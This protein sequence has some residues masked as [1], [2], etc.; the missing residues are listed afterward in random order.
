M[1]QLTFQSLCRELKS[2]PSLKKHAEELNILTGA[3]ASLIENPVAGSV[4]VFIKALSEKEKLISLGGAVL[5]A[6]LN[7]A[8]AEDYS[9]RVKR[10]QEAY[11]IIYFTAFFDELDKRLPDNIRR[12]IQLSLKEKQNLFYSSVFSEGAEHTDRREIMLPDLVCGYDEVDKFLKDMYGSMANRLQEFVRGLSFQDVAEDADIRIFDEVIKK[13]STAAVERFHDQCLILCSKFNEFYIFMQM[14]HEKRKQLKWDSQYQN[15]L[16]IAMR[17]TTSSETG[18]ANLKEIIM[19]LPKQI[20]EEKIQEIVNGLIKTYQDSINRPLIET[21]DDEESLTYPLIS[22]AFIPQAYKLLRYSGREHLEQSETWEDLDPRQDMTSFWAKYC[23]DFS[24]VENLLLILGEPGGGKSLLTKILCA[25]MIAPTN[26]CIR[27]PLREHDMEEDI[28]S[29]VCRQITLDGDASDPIRTFK[30]FAGELQGS[31]IMLLFDGY[32]EVMQATGGVY[33]NLLTRIRQFQERCQEQGRPVRVIVTSRETL[34]DK[35]DIPRK[36]T[37]M[38]LLEFDEDQKDQWIKIWNNHNHTTLAAAGLQDFALPEG[39]KDIEELSGQP[40][41]LLMLAIYDANFEAGTN[42]LKQSAGETESMDRTRL[43]DELLRRFIRRE[44]RK[45][46][47]GRDCPYEQATAK[48]QEAM[49]DEEMKKLGI[50]ALGMFVREKLS[51]KVGELESDLAYMNAKTT[52]YDSKNKKMLKSAEAVFGSFFFIHD[53]RTENEEDE[54]EAAF[55]FLH[56]TFYEFLVADLILQYLINTADYLNGQKDNAKWGDTY[57]LKALKDPNSLSNSYYAALNSSCLCTEPEIIEMIVEWKD[58]KLSKYFQEECPSFGSEMGQVLAD[59]F[60]EHMDIIRTGVFT[61]LTDKRGGL[62]GDRNYLPAC[63][64][65]LM[66]LIILQILTNGEYR[67][68]VE[69]WRYISQFLKLNVPLPQRV[70]KEETPDKR[71]IRK[72]KIDPYEEI[73]LKFMNLFLLQQEGED[74]VLTKKAHIGKAERENLQEAR[75]DAFQFMQDNVTRR[76]Y[77]LH[78]SDNTWKQRQQYIFELNQQGFDYGFKQAI[79]QLRVVAYNP[80]GKRYFSRYDILDDNIEYAISCLRHGHVDASYVLE[81]L[82]WISRTTDIML[83]LIERE[84]KI[85]TIRTRD[86]WLILAKIIFNLYA[87]E[88]EIV[89]AFLEI[90]KKLGLGSTL[91]QTRGIENILIH[92]S[93][94]APDLIMAFTETI[95]ADY[96]I[97]IHE[98]DFYHFGLNIAHILKINSPKALAAFLKLLFISGTIKSFDPIIKTNIINNWN[99]YLRKFPE[100]L[101]ALLQVCL[102]MGEFEIVKEF[103]GYMERKGTNWI[104]KLFE[105]RPDSAI[106]FL[107]VALVV[108]QEQNFGRYAM[109]CMGKDSTIAKAA[110]RHPSAVIRLVRQEILTNSIHTDRIFWT[111]VFLEQ[112]NVMFRYDLEQAVYLLFQICLKQTDFIN[113]IELITACE[114]SLQNYSLILKTS[115]KTA[116]QLLILYEKTS[117]SE[118]W[119]SLFDLRVHSLGNKETISL[120]IMHCFDKALSTRDGTAIFALGDLLDA[121]APNTRVAMEEYFIS[122]FPF[123]QTYSRN[124]AKK[125]KA[126]YEMN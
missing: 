75:M 51:L 23:L 60:R 113:Y 8:S 77:Q 104:K 47:R 2:R 40:L 52:E 41:L 91:R 112:Y 36:T 78:N 76:V 31:P 117:E 71:P 57:Y 44:L 68:N 67:I 7:Q 53:S 99:H 102:E 27:I 15:I 17:S 122:R 66:N 61:P 74:I 22:K 86:S 116:V 62:T 33:R 55:E 65:Y 63:A 72:L 6:V 12:S 64:V 85:A 18:L 98:E 9:G 10:M 114:Y 109:Q 59:I 39:N 83:Q 88:S 3:I 107:N 90:T 97:R 28:E 49:V 4:A 58:S 16:S 101:P 32:D 5:D 24:S 14:D 38:K 94:C 105:Y 89:L 42:A 56:K 25:R 108:G 120:Y 45:G 95:C 11:G 111:N 126:M 50:A 19:N 106:E 115:I 69:E 13:L 125:I 118:K 54:K 121:M 21:K 43:Y 34:I 119:K 100:E 93:N 84:N 110:S 30:S 92:L 124:L 37:V 80:K 96:Q 46:P 79:E 81:W 20:K 1:G 70:P 35:A 103:F 29:I 123:L 73:I 26:I 87:D 48:D 82:L